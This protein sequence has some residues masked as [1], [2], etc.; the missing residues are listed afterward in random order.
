MHRLCASIIK[1]MQANVLY[2]T[3]LYEENLS[4]MSQKVHVI[5]ETD[6]KVEKDYSISV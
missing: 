4:Q 1:Y 3:L 6:L 5:T 2:F